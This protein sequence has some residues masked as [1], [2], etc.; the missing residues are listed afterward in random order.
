MIVAWPYIYIFLCLVAALPVAHFLSQGGEPP[1]VPL[2][3][4]YPIHLGTILVTWL[5]TGY[6]VVYVWKT[7]TVPRNKR[8]LWT[9]LLILGNMLAMPFFW[10]HYLLKAKPRAPEEPP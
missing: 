4:V 10:Y 9:L 2:W 6:F 3:F 5:L 1:E 7:Q 8:A